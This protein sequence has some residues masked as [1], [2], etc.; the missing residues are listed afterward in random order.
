MK[1][2]SDPRLEGVLWEA[3][4]RPGGKTVAASFGD[5]LHQEVNGFAQSSAVAAAGPSKGDG[6][7]VTE[8]PTID[9]WT[10]SP[11]MQAMGEALERLA[12]MCSNGLGGSRDLRAMGQML[13]NLGQAAEEI[14]Q[15]TETLQDDH[16]VRQMAQEARVLAYVES[17]KWHRGDY[18]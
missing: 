3:Q 12:A 9:A 10:A 14:L 18:V 7:A 6:I 4:K 16:P 2:E 1:V 5:L 8:A 15:C 17:I 13:T 11:A